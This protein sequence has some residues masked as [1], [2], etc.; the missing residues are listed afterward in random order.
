MFAIRTPIVLSV[1][2]TIMNTMT[3]R[4]PRQV[5]NTRR[6]RCGEYSVLMM[7]LLQSL[8]YRAR[9]TIDRADHVS[10]GGYSNVAWLRLLSC[11]ALFCVAG[12]DGGAIKW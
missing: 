2:N 3:C 5:L 4:L 1:Q 8:G 6:G 10:T 11:I 9:W 12:V 7:R